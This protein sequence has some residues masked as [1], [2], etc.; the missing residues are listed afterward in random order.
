MFSASNHTA[1]RSATSPFIKGTS[2]TA[3]KQRSMDTVVLIALAAPRPTK[4]RM[5]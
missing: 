3:T 4:D 2:G 1:A 5:I